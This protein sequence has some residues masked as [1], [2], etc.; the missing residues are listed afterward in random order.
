MSSNSE[1]IDVAEIANSAGLS[2][3]Q[4]AEL[5]ARYRTLN[6]RERLEQVYKDF[7]PDKILVTSSFAATSAYFLHIVSTIRPD[8]VIHFIRYHRSFPSRA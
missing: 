4:I 8:Q 2:P 6:F 1:K 3:Q 7:A 5:N